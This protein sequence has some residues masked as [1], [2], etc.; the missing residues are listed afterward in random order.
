MRFFWRSSGTRTDKWWTRSSREID[1]GVPEDKLELFRRGETIFTGPFEAAA[2]RY[3]IDTVA[4]DSSS[5]RA[6]RNG[7]P[8]CDEAGWSGGEQRRGGTPDQRRSITARPWS[9]LEFSG[10]R[11]SPR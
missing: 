6:S 10:G 1:R 7:W 3:T 5:G 2:G 9:P 11:L 4:I 8:W